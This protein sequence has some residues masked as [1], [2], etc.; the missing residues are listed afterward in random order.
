M[1]FQQLLSVEE[2]VD[3]EQRE[4]SLQGPCLAARML[5]HLHVQEMEVGGSYCLSFDVPR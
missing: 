5:Q 4:D 2:P 3:Q 1:A